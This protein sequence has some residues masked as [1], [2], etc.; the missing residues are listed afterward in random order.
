MKSQKVK[1]QLNMCH[2]VT[3]E[4]HHVASSNNGMDVAKIQ[5][6]AGTSQET[7]A[8]ASAEKRNNKK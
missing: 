6:K 1:I 7:S 8:R 3:Q 4:C 2:C 5:V